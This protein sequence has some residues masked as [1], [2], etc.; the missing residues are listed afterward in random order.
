MSASRTPGTFL[1]RM[2]TLTEVRPILR[3]ALYHG[4][5]VVL[6]VFL[7]LVLLPVALQAAQAAGA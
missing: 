1:R 5:L 6:A 4:A 2:P 7:I 3:A